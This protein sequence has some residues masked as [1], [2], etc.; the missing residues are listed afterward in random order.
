MDPKCCA[1]LQG[2]LFSSISALASSIPHCEAILRDGVQVPQLDSLHRIHHHRGGTDRSKLLHF[3]GL[4]P[5][6]TFSS[7][8]DA[9]VSLDLPSIGF[10]PG[11][12]KNDSPES[13]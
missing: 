6:H 13:G 8:F 12:L 5:G 11:D 9:P 7:G 1:T 10:H 3:Q 4:D 2:T